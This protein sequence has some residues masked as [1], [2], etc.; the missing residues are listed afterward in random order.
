M[1][2]TVPSRDSTSLSL[3]LRV[4]DL[5]NRD[6]I[7]FRVLP[8]AKNRAELAEQLNIRKLRK[9][10]F[11]GTLRPDG[12]YDWRLE[13]V[14]G[15]TAV[16]DCVVTADPVTT[17]IDVPVVRKFVRQMP[18]LDEVEVEIPDDD[19]IDPLPP[20]IE[21]GDVMAEALALALPDYPRLDGATLPESVQDSDGAEPERRN[22]FAIL[23]TLKDPQ[24]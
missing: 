14:L 8:D 11:T 15:A 24:D 7:S 13:G 23:A 20:I 6:G 21:L 9:L 10:T 4:A 17:R 5:P 3:A 18:V 22:P 16:Q 19:T 12:R 2:D 1:S